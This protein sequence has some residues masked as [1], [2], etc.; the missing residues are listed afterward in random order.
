VGQ[1]A[2]SAG[3]IHIYSSMISNDPVLE[4]IHHWADSHSRVGE[5]ESCL[6]NCVAAFG[7]IGYRPPEARLRKFVQ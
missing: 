2:L 3:D 6:R 1:W 4:E 7:D 5:D